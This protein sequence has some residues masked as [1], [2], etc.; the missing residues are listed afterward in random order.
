[1]KAV[2]VSNYIN[3]HQIPFCEAMIKT[4]GSEGEFVFIQTQ[5]IEQE[6]TAMGWSSEL[7]AYVK[8]SYTDDKAHEE[9]LKCIDDADVAYV[10]W[11]TDTSLYMP[12]LKAGKLTFRISERLYKKSTLLAYNPRGLMAKYKEHT[13]FRKAP[14]Y[15]LCAGAYTASDYGIFHAYGGK[16]FR[17]GYFPELKEYGNDTPLDLKSAPGSEVRILWAGR[18]IDWKHAENALFTASKLIDAGIP[19]HMD[20]I[21]TGEMEDELKQLATAQRLMDHVSFT[22]PMAPAS[23]REYMEKADIFISTSDRQEGWGAVINEAMNSGCCVIAPA[24]AGAVPY[25]IDN[26]DNGFVFRSDDPDELAACCIQAARYPE[27]RK[28]CGEKAFETVRYTWN[29]SV[30]A[31]RLTDLARM[32]MEEW[33]IEEGRCGMPSKV[34]GKAAEIPWKTGPC[35][36]ETVRDES[37]VRDNALKYRS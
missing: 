4:M 7:P 5:E 25:L 13:A 10:G 6:R 36:I 1:M 30:A 29:A 9:C 8:C 20:M 34:P 11:T 15:L 12:R 17:W 32:L 19:F 23:V 16:M 37:V 21:G 14:V 22:G 3:H 31:E 33:G 18:F 27:I 2:F 24:E 28:N 35:S 26:G